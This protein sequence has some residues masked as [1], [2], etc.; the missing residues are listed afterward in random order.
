MTNIRGNL[1]TRHAKNINR[2]HKYSKDLLSVIIILVIYV[3]GG[4]TVFYDE[5]NMNDIL[6]RAYVLKHSHV[7][8]FIGSFDK[9]LH[10]G[11]ISTGHRA[12][13]LF[14]L[15]KSI[16]LLFVHNGAIFMKNIY[17]KKIRNIY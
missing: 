8:C 17:H 2:V 14:I 12:V 7:R 15:H 11:S 3:N 9:L 1:Y 4:E 13:L 6:K 10:E 16:F 5:E